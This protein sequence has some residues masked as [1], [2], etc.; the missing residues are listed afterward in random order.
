MEC[1]S[2]LFCCRCS[3]D[4]A[5]FRGLVVQAV[6]GHLQQ[7]QPLLGKKTCCLRANKKWK[8]LLNKQFQTFKRLRCNDSKSLNGTHTH[9][10]EQT[11]PL[12]ATTYAP[13]HFQNP[14]PELEIISN[15]G[16]H[17]CHGQKSLYWGWSSHL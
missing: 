6:F 5:S 15:G 9:T 7:R 1:P 11:R 2:G 17:M 8:I 3:D 16:Q 12:F 14:V 13:K 10:H 4:L